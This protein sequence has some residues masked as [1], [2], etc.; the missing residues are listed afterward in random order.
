MPTILH[1]RVPAFFEN[2]PPGLN[3]YMSWTPCLPSVLI[4]HVMSWLDLGPFW[5]KAL[6]I[7]YKI[8]FL[9][10]CLTRMY[11]LTFLFFQVQLNSNFYVGKFVHCTIIP[12]ICSFQFDIVE[13]VMG[14]CIFISKWVKILVIVMGLQMC[15]GFFSLR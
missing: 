15:L 12:G 14:L 8:N 3:Y 5:P 1:W 2:V 10:V 4:R 7:R 13:F 6:E 9:A 11:H